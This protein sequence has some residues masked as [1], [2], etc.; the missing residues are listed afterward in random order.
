MTANHDCFCELA[1]LYALGVLDAAEQEWVEQ[2]LAENPELMEEL[3]EYEAAVAALPYGAPGVPL[4]T[5]LKD[6]L[7]TN[8]GLALPTLSDPNPEP[9]LPPE[10]LPEARLEE[11]PFWTMRSQDIPWA[12][13]PTPGVQ[14]AILYTDPI[15]R[16]MTGLLKAAPG[17]RYPLHRHA[18]IEELYM[19]EGDLI[20]AD[21]V[22]GAG[23]Y[24]RSY[25]GSMHDPQ[26]EGGCMFFFR[27]S[28]DDEY[29]LD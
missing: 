17:V 26:T 25:P 10:D 16:E 7:F 8:L 3:A 15:K 24:I 1:P 4:A 28:M 14:V 18:E 29:G 23:D 11:L 12:P 5:D 27:T 6:R 19:L 22:Y 2:Q 13:H 20:I 9:P 21:Q